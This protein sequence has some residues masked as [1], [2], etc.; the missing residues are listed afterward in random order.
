[1]DDIIKSPH[2][3]AMVGQISSSERSISAKIQ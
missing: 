2:L 1:M 3:H